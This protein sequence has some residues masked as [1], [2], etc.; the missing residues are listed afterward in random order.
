MTPIEYLDS[1]L[2]AHREDHHDVTY[3][4]LVKLREMMKVHEQDIIVETLR[5]IVAMLKTLG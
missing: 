4:E 3:A 5:P 1:L 2:L